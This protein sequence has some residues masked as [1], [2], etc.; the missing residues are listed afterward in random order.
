MQS[1]ASVM[2]MAPVVNEKSKKILEKK[3]KLEEDGQQ[4][5]ATQKK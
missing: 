4:E 2:N 1:E 3:R 5:D